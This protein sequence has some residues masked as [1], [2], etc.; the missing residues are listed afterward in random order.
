MIYAEG[1]PD[2]LTYMMVRRLD[3]TSRKK[4]A[5]RLK[6]ST[7]TPKDAIPEASSGIKNHFS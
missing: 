4:A 6:G 5:G 7:E 3:L 1:K 2:T